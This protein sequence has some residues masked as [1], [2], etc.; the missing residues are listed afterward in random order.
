MDSY[1]HGMQHDIQKTARRLPY[2][3]SNE[4]RSDLDAYFDHKAAARPGD[5]ISAEK[6][7]KELDYIFP[8]KQSKQAKSIKARV[9]PPSSSQVLAFSHSESQE[10]LN[11]Y[12]DNLDTSTRSHA[13]SDMDST[14]QKYIENKRKAIHDSHGS[15]TVVGTPGVL[16]ELCFLD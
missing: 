15:F 8:T 13:W 3:S 7:L 16:R 10:D 5:Y 11:D 12:F 4:A 2:R 9:V 14:S 6:A 1:F